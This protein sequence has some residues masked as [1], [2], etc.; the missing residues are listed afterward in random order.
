MEFWKHCCLVPNAPEGTKFHTVSCAILSLPVKVKLPLSFL[1]FLCLWQGLALV[2]APCSSRAPQDDP[3]AQKPQT[4]QSPARPQHTVSSPHDWTHINTR[5]RSDGKKREK[6]AGILFLFE[7]RGRVSDF[8]KTI[9]F[10]MLGFLSK[11]KMKQTKQTLEESIYFP[12]LLTIS[13]PDIRSI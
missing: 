6:L 1:R 4:G 3:H 5:S 9:H 8:A 11:S 2:F 12:L 13:P 7:A 10:N